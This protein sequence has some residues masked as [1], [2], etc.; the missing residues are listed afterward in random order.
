MQSAFAALIAERYS[1]HA[2]LPNAKINPSGSNQFA[3]QISKLIFAGTR[4]YLD[5]YVVCFCRVTNDDDYQSGLLSQWRAYGQGGG[6]AIELDV[7]KLKR[8]FKESNLVPDASHHIFAD[9]TYTA[10]RNFEKAWQVAR[11]TTERSLS[12]LFRCMDEIGAAKTPIDDEVVNEFMK[13]AEEPLRE[14]TGRV[15][16]LSCFAKNRAFIEER[17]TRLVVTAPAD[18]E[19]HYKMRNNLVLPFIKI[20]GNAGTSLPISRILIGPHADQ[21]RRKQ[22][23]EHLL[24]TRRREVRV[25]I[26]G[27]PFKGQQA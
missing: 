4:R 27:I 8:M 2:K 5:A 15:A 6:A 24:R 7:R 17:E 26:S 14:L 10:T 12:N 25:D 21:L 11:R 20:F 18:V 23:I 22:G 16:I 9:V 19:R 13:L 1:D 3:E